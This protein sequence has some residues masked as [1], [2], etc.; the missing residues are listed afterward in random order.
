MK[1]L[2]VSLLLIPTAFAVGF[3]LAWVVL[4]GLNALLPPFRPEDDDTWREIGPVALAYETWAA[5]TLTGIILAWRRERQ[6]RRT[7]PSS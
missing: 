1:H 3:V 5:T 4:F 2:L 6:A 7:P